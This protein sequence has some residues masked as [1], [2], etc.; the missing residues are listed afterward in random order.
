MSEA[1]RLPS[2]A[3]MWLEQN[4]VSGANGSR[5]TQEIRPRPAG[6]GLTLPRPLQGPAWFGPL[7]SRPLR[8]VP[9]PAPRTPGPREPD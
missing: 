7:P 1:D 9:W 4:A 3:E 2:A 5:P 8:P 6:P